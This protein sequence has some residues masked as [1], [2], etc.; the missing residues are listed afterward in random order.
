MIELEHERDE[1]ARCLLQV[2]DKDLYETVLEFTQ[3]MLAKLGRQHAAGRSGWAVEDDE[4]WTLSDIKR[5]LSDHVDK[6]D[7]I[8]CANYAL[9]W[10]YHQRRLERTP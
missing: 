7:P 8:D 3:A 10:W 6:G 4:E 1:I 5:H 9:F 2:A